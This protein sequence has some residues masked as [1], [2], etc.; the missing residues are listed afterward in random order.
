MKTLYSVIQRVQVVFIINYKEVNY[1]SY[2][3]NIAIWE[4]F[5]DKYL[6]AQEHLL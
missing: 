5:Y 1:L 4:L 3:I 2:Y 6:C